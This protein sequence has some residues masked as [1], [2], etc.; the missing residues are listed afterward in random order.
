MVV[1]FFLLAIAS[2]HVLPSQLVAIFGC[3][4]FIFL[5]PHIVIDQALQMI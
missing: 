5:R 4:D 2:A 1:T 3:C